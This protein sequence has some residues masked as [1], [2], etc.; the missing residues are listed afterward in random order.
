MECISEGARPGAM[1][2]DDTLLV[3][4]LLTSRISLSRAL[5]GL[6]LVVASFG[7]LGCRPPDAAAPTRPGIVLISL[8]TVRRD[9][10]GLYLPADAAQPSATPRLDA[11][12][13]SAAVFERAYAAVPFTLPSHLSMLTGVYPDVHGVD[14][15]NE[16]LNPSIP[17]LAQILRRDG[18][19]TLAVVSNMW[20]KP[21]FGLERGFDHYERIDY[22]LTY[23]QRINT[24][25][26]ELLDAPREGDADDEPTFL[27]LHY[28]DAHSDFFSVGRNTLPYYAPPE[29]LAELGIPEGDESFCDEGGRCATKYLI[30]ADVE[31]R[32]IPAEQMEKIRALYRAGIRSLD[33]DLGLLFDGLRAR[34]LWDDAF[35]IVTADHGEEF[36]EHGGLIHSQPYVENLAVPLIVKMPD[37]AAAGTRPGALVETLDLPSTVLDYLGLEAPAHL[38]GKSF[39]PVLRGERS[40]RR[41]TFGR[42]KKK[43]RKF[44]L[45]TERFTL[46]EDLAAGKVE[47]FDLHDDPQELDNV[48][49]RHPERTAELRALLRKA[50]EENSQRAEEL[51]ATSLTEG[52]LLTPE[53]EERLR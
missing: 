17:T 9:A 14:T 15:R 3:M 2:G 30:A 36:R 33:R 21:G 10:L 52:S 20:M 40:S 29:L 12:A 53:E 13:D 27:F 28:V 43:R 23:S 22:S 6:G 47:L 16:V 50:V 18:Y 49:A 4:R 37:A 26:F 42:D 11:L 39:L 19:R 44:A 34:G 46:V 45:R 7:A 31:G 35:V 51:S 8:D 25:A 1:R 48:A 5:A 38:Q 24:R 32:E 41:F